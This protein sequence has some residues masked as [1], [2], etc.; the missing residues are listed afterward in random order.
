MQITMEVDGK[1]VFF[2]DLNDSVENPEEKRIS[3][4]NCMMHKY[5]KDV[6]EKEDKDWYR[7]VSGKAPSR[8]LEVW[9][10]LSDKR[11]YKVMTV[12][13]CDPKNIAQ[14]KERAVKGVIEQMQE[15]F[16]IIREPKYLAVSKLLIEEIVVEEREE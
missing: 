14:E 16:F 5:Y 7:N 12:E 13:I 2:S 3:E 10:Y 1:I 11:A 6:K 15:D 4:R 8:Y 9:V